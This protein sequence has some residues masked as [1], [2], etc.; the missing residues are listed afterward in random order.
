MAKQTDAQARHYQENKDY[1][2]KKAQRLKD[3]V[4]QTMRQLKESTPCADCGNMFPFYVMDFD[5]I[6]GEKLHNISTLTNT[7][8]TKRLREELLKCEIVCAN[9]HRERTYRRGLMDKATDFES[10]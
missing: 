5:H 7:G 1:Y 2:K 8:Q 6:S 3:A 4:K 10:V 9:C